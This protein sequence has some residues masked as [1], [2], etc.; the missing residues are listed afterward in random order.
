MFCRYKKAFDK[1]NKNCLC[2]KLMKTGIRGKALFC[3][4]NC[5][6]KINDHYADPFDV[7]G[8][9]QGC[10]LYPTLFRIYINDSA[11]DIKSLNYGVSFDNKVLSL[12]MYT[13]NIAVIASKAASVQ[14][15]LAHLTDW[16]KKWRLLINVDKTI[17]IRFRQG[18]SVQRSLF[19]FDCRD[20]II[21]YNESN[22]HLAIW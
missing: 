16:Y 18:K 20:I 13:D 5:A 22:R 9:K 1:L 7:N 10:K 11:D 3:N 17:T 19:Y 21:C 14:R 8:V 15:M 6:V 4:I 12:L 2:F